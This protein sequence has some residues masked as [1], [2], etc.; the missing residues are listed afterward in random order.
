MNG[1]IG[2][3]K[4]S[5]RSKTLKLSTISFEICR[6]LLLTINMITQ[7]RPEKGNDINLAKTNT[8]TRS[9]TTRKRKIKK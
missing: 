7:K 5:A 9:K 6:V 8:S 4:N 2:I 1:N 3:M